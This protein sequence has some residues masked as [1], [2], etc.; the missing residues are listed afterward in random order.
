MGSQLML[1][2][3]G[4][5]D[6]VDID[7][8]EDVLFGIVTNIRDTIHFQAETLA[9]LK[10]EFRFSVDDY[11]AFCAEKGIEPDK[12]CSGK[13]SLRV[14]PQVHSAAISAATIEGI[15]LNAWI[16]KTIKKAAIS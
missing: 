5:A 2:Y 6:K 4:Y 3:K 12:P 13:I 1:T 9:Q 14:S 10:K 15:S 16:S 7:F 11:L 8:E